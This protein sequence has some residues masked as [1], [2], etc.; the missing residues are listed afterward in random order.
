MVSK[1]ADVNTNLETT[2]KVTVMGE[3]QSDSV[4]RYYWKASWEARWL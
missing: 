3:V 4:L 2:L 1:M